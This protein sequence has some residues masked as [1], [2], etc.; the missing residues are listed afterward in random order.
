MTST[1]TDHPNA[2]GIIDPRAVGRTRIL[3]GP[4]CKKKKKRFLWSARKVDA[5]WQKSMYS[6]PRYDQ[7]Y[8][9]ESCKTLLRTT[10][11]LIHDVL[12]IVTSTSRTLPDVLEQFEDSVACDTAA[13]MDTTLHADFELSTI[14][15]SA[16]T[17]LL[18]TQPDVHIGKSSKKNDLEGFNVNPLVVKLSNALR[19]RPKQNRRN[20][21]R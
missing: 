14:P 2:T 20:T 19:T 6:A 12:S 3:I 21:C 17:S 4:S 16:H 18:S 11:P 15:P 10:T 1:P 5:L 7:L 9:P 8:S 13:Q